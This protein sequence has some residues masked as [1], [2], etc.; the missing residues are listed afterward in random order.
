VTRDALEEVQLNAGIRHRRQGSVAE[1]V[2]HGGGTRSTR[3][4]ADPIA[5]VKHPVALNHHVGF[6][7]QVLPVDRPEVALA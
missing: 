5:Q 6:L 3:S 1:S 7:Q 2:T 4:T